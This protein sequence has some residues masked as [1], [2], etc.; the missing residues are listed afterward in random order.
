MVLF[1]SRLFVFLCLLCSFQLWQ[2]KPFFCRASLPSLAGQFTL[3]D[4]QAAVDADFVE[5]RTPCAHRPRAVV[6][7]ACRMYYP[8]DSPRAACATVVL[9]PSVLL[10]DNTK[11]QQPSGDVQSAFYAFRLFGRQRIFL[12]GSSVNRVNARRASRRDVLPPLLCSPRPH[13]VA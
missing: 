13:S 7:H 12:R 3:E 8:R 10:N 6:R 11:Q 2:K 5:V 9:F 4:V 1:M